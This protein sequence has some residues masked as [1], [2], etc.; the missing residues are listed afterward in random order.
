MTSRILEIA[1]LVEYIARTD[2]SN[3]DKK[4]E[5]KNVQHNGTI[6]LDEALD[7]LCEYVK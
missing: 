2:I 6:T 1:E 4:N 7:L 3:E 5:I